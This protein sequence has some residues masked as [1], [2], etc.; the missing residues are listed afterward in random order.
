MQA[1]IGQSIQNVALS[2]P[3]A[4]YLYFDLGCT[5]PLLLILERSGMAKSVYQRLK[6]PLGY[7]GS[8]IDTDEA[9]YEPVPGQQGTLS[10][11]PS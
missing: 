6:M 3:D 11:T 1:L 5:S 4:A 2:P 8:A 10:S 7:E 9:C